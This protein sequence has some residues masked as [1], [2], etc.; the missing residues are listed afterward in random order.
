MAKSVNAPRRPR[1]QP[2][3]LVDIEITGDSREASL[4]LEGLDRAFTPALM[5][6]NLFARRIHND[7]VDQIERRFASET[8]PGGEKWAPL[9]EYTQEM[10]EQGGFGPAHPINVRTGAMKR[11]LLDSQPSIVPTPMQVTYK[12]PG[13][14]G[15]ADMQSKVRTSSIGG[16]QKGFRDTPPRPI[17]GLDESDL[18]LVLMNISLHIADFQPGSGTGMF[19]T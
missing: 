1:K 12:Y 16:Q 15:D 14:T 19:E 11:H 18:G 8:G 7:I 9:A 5:A 6:L 13:D 3:G 10:R 4:R 17:L 2:A